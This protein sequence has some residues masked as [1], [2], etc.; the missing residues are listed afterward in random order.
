MSSTKEK[1][2]HNINKND[3]NQQ[4]P[5]NKV[6][7]AIETFQ[8]KIDNIENLNFALEE[9][10]AALIKKIKKD[11]ST[12]DEN[13]R[14][15]A[16]FMAKVIGL[17]KFHISDFRENIDY[18]KKL[19]KKKKKS[20]DD[21]I[22]YGDIQD[23]HTYINEPSQPLL[24]RKH[25]EHYLK[26]FR[27][28]R[29]KISC[30]RDQKKDRLPKKD[31]RHAENHAQFMRIVPINEL[32][33][34]IIEV[35]FDKSYSSDQRLPVIVIIR[36]DRRQHYRKNRWASAISRAIVTTMKLKLYGFE[37]N[38]DRIVSILFMKFKY[39]TFPFLQHDVSREKIQERYSLPS[40]GRAEII[41]SATIDY[42]WSTWRKMTWPK[43]QD[44]KIYRTE[45]QQYVFDY[46][47]NSLIIVLPY[48]TNSA[49][50]AF[51]CSS[52]L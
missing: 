31:I 48:F 51:Q 34:L 11:G 41:L 14:T 33:D 9:R 2:M 17:M 10:R 15:E 20:E 46:L 21:I 24:N 13:R 4:A 25:Y 36:K 27:Q 29:K 22:T 37:N 47:T 32:A 30:S 52:C 19:L 35:G 49:N 12:E 26:K 18:W 43:F 23:M 38:T 5:L 50:V 16:S 42:K 39:F 45:R 8:C 3:P 28:E 44:R 6:K 7:G 1:E 40:D